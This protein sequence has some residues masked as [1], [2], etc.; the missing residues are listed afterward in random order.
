[1]TIEYIIEKSGEERET[2]E[3]FIKTLQKYKL[4]GN[5]YSL[6]NRALETFE[7]IIQLQKNNSEFTLSYYI[8]KEI[9]EEYGEDI[10]IKFY[11]SKESILNDLLWK[12]ENEVVRVEKRREKF[13]EDDHIFRTLVDN[14]DDTTIAAEMFQKDT[15]GKQNFNLCFKCLG[16]NYIYYLAG[17]LNTLTLKEEMHVFYNEG[18]DFNIMKCKYICGGNC[19]KGKIGTIFKKCINLTSDKG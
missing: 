4:I 3:Q 15:G 1:M 6:D 17:R 16:S 13:D 2:V 14:F 8:E 19:E 12:I 10:H 9:Q 7:K 11:W 18:L 5:N